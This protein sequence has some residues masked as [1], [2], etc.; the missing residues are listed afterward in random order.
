MLISIFYKTHNV[1]KKVRAEDGRTFYVLRDFFGSL[2]PSFAKANMGDA[3][4]SVV[5]NCIV[6]LVGFFVI[7]ILSLNHLR[8]LDN[9]QLFPPGF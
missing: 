5:L 6:V 2:T 4:A 3:Y 9:N 1:Y 8:W 7:L